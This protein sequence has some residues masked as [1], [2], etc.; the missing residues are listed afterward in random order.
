MT[1]LH[2]AANLGNTNFGS[3][4]LQHGANPNAQTRNGDTP[5]H[6]CAEKGNIE[7]IQLLLSHGA[8][9]TL[10]NQDPTNKKGGSTP[11]DTAKK[12]RNKKCAQLLQLT[13]SRLCFFSFW[14]KVF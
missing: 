10:R 5:L 9:R 8:D 2:W 4:L 14:K 3:I 13:K 1:P 6:F 12:F 7:F 11:Y